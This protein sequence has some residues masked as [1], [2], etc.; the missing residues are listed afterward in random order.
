VGG[1]YGHVWRS[2]DNLQKSVPF[3]HVGPGIEFRLSDLAARTFIHWAISPA[4]FTPSPFPQ[5]VSLSPLTLRN[6]CSVVH[7]S[8]SSLLLRLFLVCCCFNV[9]TVTS[10]SVCF[11]LLSS[12]IP[13]SAFEIFAPL[14]KPWPLTCWRRPS[15]TEQFWHS[16]MTSSHFCCQDV[17]ECGLRPLA[18]SSSWGEILLWPL[19]HAFS[20][21]FLGTEENHFC[22]EF[23]EMD[24]GTSSSCLSAKRRI[25]SSSALRRP[26]ASTTLMGRAVSL[27]HLLVTYS[28]VC[29]FETGFLRETLVILKLTL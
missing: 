29:L 22:D 17:R 9:L 8:S 23:R 27:T 14:L 4:L 2:E 3:Y 21:A 19:Y 11:I 24:W 7:V 20:W 18:F 28:I 6:I 1:C 13:S 25:L 26:W 12:P 10:C 5:H 16:K 15:H